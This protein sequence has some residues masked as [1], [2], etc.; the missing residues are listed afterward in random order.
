MQCQH[1]NWTFQLLWKV[2]TTLYRL[3]TCQIYFS[4][5]LQ[6]QENTGSG[7]WI[8][9]LCH[10]FQSVA[11]PRWEGKAEEKGRRA[12]RTSPRLSQGPEDHT[13]LCW[14]TSGRWGK[15]PERVPQKVRS[16]D[17]AYIKA[18]WYCVGV[19]NIFTFLNYCYDLQVGWDPQSYEQR[20]K[21]TVT[22]IFWQK[23]W[24]AEPQ[25]AGQP[26]H[27]AASTRGEFKCGVNLVKQCCVLDF[28]DCINVSSSGRPFAL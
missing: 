18:G 3:I 4:L 10:W 21:V 16:S 27:Y 26:K 28:Q 24:K 14:Q 13:R 9:L 20:V 25:R 6:C 17:D 7:R 5:Q 1:L 11:V 23:R 19:P 8:G 15:Q 22:R 12:E 2:V